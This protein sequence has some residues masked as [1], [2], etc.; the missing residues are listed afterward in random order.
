VRKM[1]PLAS[2]VNGCQA[3]PQLP[4]LVLCASCLAG[5]DEQAR[6]EGKAEGA[7]EERERG[8]VFVDLDAGDGWIRIPI[9]EWEG[10]ITA[11]SGRQGRDEGET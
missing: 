11:P 5:L 7:R 9:G 6:A 8:A 4:S 1:R 3:V 2:C 10:R